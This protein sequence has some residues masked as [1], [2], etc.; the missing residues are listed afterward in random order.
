MKV[1][2]LL[3]IFGISSIFFIA[4]I[5]SSTTSVTL[6]PDSKKVVHYR[7]DMPKIELKTSITT[8]I[9]FNLTYLEP[10]SQESKIVEQGNFQI[11]IKIDIDKPGI[12]QFEFLSSEIA[13]IEI[14]GRGIYQES[15]FVFFGS[16][17]II[18]FA[19]SFRYFR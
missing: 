1:P 9:Q 11:S 13:K 15:L 5:I 17:I 7:S 3:I 16:L 19:F 2:T 18:A 12:Y 4:P 6:L 10:F 14:K 8:P